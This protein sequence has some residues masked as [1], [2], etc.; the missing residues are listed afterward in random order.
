MLKYGNGVEAIAK[1]AKQAIEEGDI[2]VLA[3]AMNSAQ[4]L[5]DGCASPNCP[6]ELTSPRLHHL[7][8]DTWLKNNSLAIKGVGS[9]GDGSAQI[10]CSSSEQQALVSPNNSVFFLKLSISLTTFYLQVYEY[11]TSSLHLP[12]FILKISGDQ[13]L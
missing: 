1:D 8:T 12:A 11:V 5:F 9:Q 7:I 2:M 13:N 3:D 4:S 6:S 10:L